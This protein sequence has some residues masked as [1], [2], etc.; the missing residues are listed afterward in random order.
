MK[1]LRLIVSLAALILATATQAQGV[2]AGAIQIDRAYAR[3][4]APGQ[5]AGGAYLRLDNRGPAD[6]LLVASADVSQ[7]VELHEMKMEADVMR[8]RQVDA[9]ELP[10]NK[11]VELKPGGLHI[12]LIGL[13]APLKAG[14]RFPMTLRFEKAGEVKLDVAVEA[15]KPAGPGHHDMK[16]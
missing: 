14:E 7:R 15:V 6:R 10:A 4:T 2:K 8:M 5:P 9:I 13:K 11:V 12:M 1:Q 16:H 3:A